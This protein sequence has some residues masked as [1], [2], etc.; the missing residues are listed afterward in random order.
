MEGVLEDGHHA[1][2][3]ICPCAPRNREFGLKTLYY[4]EYLNDGPGSGT[5][6]Q[7]DWSGFKVLS[8]AAEAEL[9]TAG[10]FIGG[11]GWLGSTGF[12]FTNGV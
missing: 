3:D 10:Q 5:S 9:L 1:V 12:L 2:D 8:S 4:R 6:K 11:G 7:V